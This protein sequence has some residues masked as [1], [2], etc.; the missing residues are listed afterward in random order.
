MA[1]PK[2]TVVMDRW[3]EAHPNPTPAEIKAKDREIAWMTY[4]HYMTAPF[5]K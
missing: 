1:F 2:I 5:R 3:D 4:A